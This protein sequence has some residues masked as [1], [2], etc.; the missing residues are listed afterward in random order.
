[1]HMVYYCSKIIN[2]LKWFNK[3]LRVCLN[4]NQLPKLP[5]IKLLFF[6]TSSLKNIR[7]K[8]TAAVLVTDYICTVWNNRDNQCDKIYLLKKKI[9]QRLQFN[10]FILKDKMVDKFNREY[11]NINQRFLDNIDIF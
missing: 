5:M 1:M 8:N 10:T 7:N 6:D 11:S 9:L 2:V 4:I 3:L